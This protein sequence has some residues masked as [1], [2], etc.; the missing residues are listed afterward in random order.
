MFSSVHSSTSLLRWS[1]IIRSL[2]S[3]ALDADLSMDINKYQSFL[4]DAIW[5]ILFYCNLIK[6][7]FEK[8]EECF[9]DALIS[10]KTFWKR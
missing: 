7:L 5:F 6:T 10:V 8:S 4:S 2:D 1:K 3:I 9:C